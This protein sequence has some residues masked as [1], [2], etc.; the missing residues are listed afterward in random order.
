[1]GSAADLGYEKWLEKIAEKVGEQVAESGCVLV[2][3]AEKDGDSLS[4][5]ACRGAKR[6]GGI[7]VGV[8]YGKGKT[9]TETPDI[10]VPAGMERGGGREFVL[11]LMCD[12]II[13]IGGGSGTLTEI[14]MAYQAGIPV[15]VIEK[16]G[17]WSEKTANSYLDGRK[18]L[19]ICS[20]SCPEKAVEMA[21]QKSRESA[22]KE[23]SGIRV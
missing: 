6:K 16:S 8:T 23:R 19:K 2:F 3:G 18:R 21:I 5:A 15:I 20:A 11:V 22:N 10:I 9:V 13:S 4:A 14:A 1:M 17:G 12:A 7:T